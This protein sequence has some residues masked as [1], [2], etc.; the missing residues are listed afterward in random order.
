MDEF[1][2]MDRMMS[3]FHQSFGM[4][5]MM[6]LPP[7]V[8]SD[9]RPQAR[10]RRT[11]HHHQAMMPFGGGMFGRSMFQEMDSMMVNNNLFYKIRDFIC[12]II[13]LDSSLTVL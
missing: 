11:S 9:R 10:D 6:A 12:S 3:S 8:G 1:D 13:L 2:Q 4:P 5:S 7:G